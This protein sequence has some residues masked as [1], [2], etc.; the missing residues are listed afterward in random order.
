V[1][2]N[3]ENNIELKGLDKIGAF[4]N[5]VTDEIHISGLNASQTYNFTIADF[6]GSVVATKLSIKDEVFYTLRLY[7]LSKGLYYLTV[8]SNDGKKTFKFLKQ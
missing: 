6:K 3:I 4:P 2:N 5:P 1:R 7:N 8:S